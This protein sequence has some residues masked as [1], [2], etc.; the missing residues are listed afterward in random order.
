MLTFIQLDDNHILYGDVIFKRDTFGSSIDTIGLNAPGN[1]SR[2]YNL[3]DPDGTIWQR[4][5]NASITLPSS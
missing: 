2:T 5:A 4:M 1:V 3:P